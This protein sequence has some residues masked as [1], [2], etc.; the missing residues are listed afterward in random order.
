MIS[1]FESFRSKVVTERNV[2][3]RTCN[4]VYMRTEGISL[5]EWVCSLE[6]GCKHRK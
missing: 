5:S 4:N 6:P 1:N 3:S 2:K